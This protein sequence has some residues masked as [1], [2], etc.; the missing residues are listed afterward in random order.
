MSDNWLRPEFQGREGELETRTGFYERT[1]ITEEAL[2]SMFVRYANRAPKVVKRFGKKQ[3][4]VIAELDT[5][6]AWIAENSGKRSNAEVKRSE[7]ARLVKSI[8]EAEDRVS[9]R[10]SD[11]KKAENSLALRKR[12]HKRALDELA[13][14]EQTE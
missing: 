12:Q 4:F 9:D 2:S 11:L 7:V 13:F 6:V 14:L 1:G 3:H 8:E 5:F 10:L